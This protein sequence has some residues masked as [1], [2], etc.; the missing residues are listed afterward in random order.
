MVIIKVVKCLPMGVPRF[1]EDN[2]RCFNIIS[3]DNIFM[4]QLISL[5]ISW[6]ELL[7]AQGVGALA[8]GCNKLRTFISKV[9]LQLLPL[10]CKDHHPLFCNHHP[11]I[12]QGCLHI[13]D[14]ALFHL[15]RFCSNLEQVNFQGCRTIMDEGD[16][17]DGDHD[18]DGDAFP[19]PRKSTFRVVRPS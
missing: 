5:N 13:G 18:V 10:Q 16:C 15:A 19:T 11:K 3:R 8:E 12:S 14:L 6:C 9:I 2:E 4:L 1:Q 17:L 7:T